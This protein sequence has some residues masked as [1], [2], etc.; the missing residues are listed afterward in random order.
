MP[1]RPAGAV[2]SGG[3]DRTGGPDF[4]LGGL[5]RRFDPFNAVALIR[6]PGELGFGDHNPEAP[7][8]T[9]TRKVR[10]CVAG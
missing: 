5:V 8:A 9:P 1:I 7:P 4:W 6:E 10:S 3:P 2:P